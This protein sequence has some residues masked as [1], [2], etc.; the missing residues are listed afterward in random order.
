MH[1]HCL[2]SARTTPL[3]SILPCRIAQARENQNSLLG[4]DPKA[5]VG[6]RNA[7]PNRHRGHAPTQ[8][9]L[10]VYFVAG[11]DG[12]ADATGEVRVQ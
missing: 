5:S 1:A 12:R 2:S 10:S 6:N 3:A 11:Y 8:S 7:S 9:W 4:T